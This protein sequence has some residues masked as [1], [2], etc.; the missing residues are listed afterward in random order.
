MHHLAEILSSRNRTLRLWELALFCV[1]AGILST[2]LHGYEYMT[3]DQ[4]E[5]IPLIL[6]KLDANYLTSDYFISAMSVVSPRIYFV[7]MMA[8]LT[9]FASLETIYFSL[10]LIQHIAIALVT[11]FAA[12]RLF[13]GGDLAPILATTF[14]VSIAGIYIGGAAHL[15]LNYMVPKLLI[16]FLA[17]WAVWEGVNLHP[18]RCAILTI[19]GSWIHPQVAIHGA[20]I[21]F[22]TAGLSLLM[23]WDGETV[24]TNSLVQ[25]WAGITLGGALLVVVYY[26]LWVVPFRGGELSMEVLQ[27]TMRLRAPH[28]HIPSL[29]PRDQ[30]LLGIVFFVASALLW[31]RWYKAE[32]T[33]RLLAKRV[34]VAGGLCLIFMLSA[35]LFVEV[36]PVRAVMM[37]QLFRMAAVLK[38]FA[39]MLM[40]GTV[41]AL[42][43]SEQKASPPSP[44]WLYLTGFG[45]GQPVMMLG[46]TI[47]DWLR[48]KLK[49][50]T[51]FALFVVAALIQ[52]ALLVKFRGAREFLSLYII[53][54]CGVVLLV[55]SAR[56]RRLLWSGGMVAVA[57][58]LSLSYRDVIPAGPLNKTVQA[59]VNGVTPKDE[60]A[61]D[62]A[63]DRVSVYAREST[64]QDAL[65]IV[66]AEFGRFRIA[67]HRAVVVDFKTFPFYERDIIEWRER[68][69]TCYGD[70][71][72]K[73]GWEAVKQ[74]NENYR[75]MND[76]E[77]LRISNRY[78][79]PYAVLYAE[80]AT[81]F[82]LLYEDKDF[83]LVRVTS[84][85]DH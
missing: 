15:E 1:A 81:S 16:L 39:L 9:Q 34:G 67:S 42:L 57:L 50:R 23:R 56:S 52:I 26:F 54:L 33:D 20:M 79:A 31:R 61:F 71:G 25:R 70:T 3:S 32:S 14:V 29:F 83:K 19:V 72:D 73:L 49:T 38:W 37:L 60:R 40:G 12:R 58:L 47:V 18:I 45:M 59:Y 48:A 62:R 65:F 55:I 35:W 66:P 10:T 68:I 78:N 51:Y 11:M 53:L 75:R 36:I 27:Y 4:L 84:N 63:V 74:M 24:Q 5:Q 43:L 8:W 30:T 76:A 82:P 46:A 64:P 80:T 85:Q 6:R 28:H 69:E 2:L 77:L 44:N 13:P 21:G 17:L 22:G 41:A 7:N